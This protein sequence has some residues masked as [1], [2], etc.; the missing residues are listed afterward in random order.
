MYEACSS[1]LAACGTCGCEKQFHR[2]IRNSF[3][4]RLW[5]CIGC[6]ELDLGENPVSNYILCENLA[7]CDDQ[8]TCCSVADM[9]LDQENIGF[10]HEQIEDI[11]FSDFEENG[12]LIEELGGR[13]IGGYNSD[14]DVEL[15]QNANS[16]QSEEEMN[17]IVGDH[18]GI[19]S[20][21]FFFCVLI[22]C[23]VLFILM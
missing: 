8:M 2:M 18:I 7:Q 23:F 11:N 20:T 21:K 10:Q 5:C 3:S 16:Y 14:N 9:D 19:T 15:E 22:F 1:R 4:E 12:S 6:A 13:I 17:E